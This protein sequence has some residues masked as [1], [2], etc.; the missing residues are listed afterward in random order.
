MK[1]DSSTECLELCLLILTRVQDLI[2][3]VGKDSRGN[4]AASIVYHSKVSR[5]S[6]EK[7]RFK[8]EHHERSGKIYVLIARKEYHVLQCHRVSKE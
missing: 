3:H 4:N 5:T 6:L 8:N 1:N 2:L 7:V